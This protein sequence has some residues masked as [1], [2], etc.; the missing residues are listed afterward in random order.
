MSAI[1]CEG[2]KNENL[3]VM[4]NLFQLKSMMITKYV[5]VV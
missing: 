3:H 5:Y 2:A 4:S 1:E